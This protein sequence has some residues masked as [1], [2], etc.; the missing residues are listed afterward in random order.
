MLHDAVTAP[1]SPGVCDSPFHFMNLYDFD[2]VTTPQ[3]RL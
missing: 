2:T 3:C 1:G